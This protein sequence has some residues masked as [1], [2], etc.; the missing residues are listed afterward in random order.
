M[1]NNIA[2]ITT[3][4]CDL[5]CEHCLRGYPKDRPDFPMGLLDKLLTEA[6]P[7]GARYVGLTGGEAHLHPQFEQMVEK[8]VAYGYSWH[9]VSHGQRTEPYLPLMEKY[10]DHFQ[11][12]AISIDGAVAS[13]HDE[14][15]Q[16]KGAFDRAI[17]SVKQ[18][19]QAGYKVKI[20]TVLNQRNK[21]EMEA[22][23]NLARDLGVSSIGVGGVI[24]ITWNKHLSLS[25]EESLHL[26]QEAKDLREK[27]GFDVK[28]MSCLHTRGGVNFC[29]V[30]NFHK[31]TFNSRGE[32]IFCCD[33]IERET[34]IGSLAE[35]S[36]SSLAQEWI[37]QSSALQRE[38]ATR[39]ANGNLGQG[40]DTCAFCNDYFTRR[41]Y[42]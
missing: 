32:L 14:I 27:T 13:T 39:I 12:V 22:M 1:L 10:R 18:Y 4:R 19:V 29:N 6:I 11:H 35:Q 3:L 37:S 23:V 36:F 31:L 30:L 34:V 38:R 33:T 5:K 40:F 20:S 9:F 25:D 41:K 42:H 21:H 17:G 2:I 26:W 24:P 16:K 7:F 8:I 28:T 15:R